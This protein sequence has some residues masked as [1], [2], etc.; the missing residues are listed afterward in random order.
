PRIPV[1]ADVLIAHPVQHR[2]DALRRGDPGRLGQKIPQLYHRPHRGVECSAGQA[3][4]LQVLLQEGVQ[5][6]RDRH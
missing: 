2:P 6:L 4:D 3:A 5:G 1:Q